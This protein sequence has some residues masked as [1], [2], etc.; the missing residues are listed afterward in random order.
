MHPNTSSATY[1]RSEVSLTRVIIAEGLLKVLETNQDWMA[2]GDS[3]G[4]VRGDVVFH[5]LPGHSAYVP[6]ITASTPLSVCRR[7]M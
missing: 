3:I 4:R 2:L 1:R 6:D 7:A 5:M